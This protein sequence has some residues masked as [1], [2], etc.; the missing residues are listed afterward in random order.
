MSYEILSRK[1]RRAARQTSRHEHKRG[2][3]GSTCV[4]SSFT[5]KRM[6]DLPL[7]VFLFVL[8]GPVIALLWLLVKCTSPGPGLYRQQRVGR[9]GRTYF[10]Y[11][12]RSM[13]QD[14]EVG[15]GAVWCSTGEPRGTP[16]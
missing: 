6:I 5:W 4:S 1:R 11:K 10:M 15:T 13:R 16:L 14:A 2:T 8:A 9:F 7:A 12:M 3:I